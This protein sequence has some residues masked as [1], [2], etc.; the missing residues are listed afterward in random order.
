M[1]SNMA[2]VLSRETLEKVAMIIH[3]EAIAQRDC[4]F[5]K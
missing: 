1:S 4:Q 3:D 2:G 5:Q